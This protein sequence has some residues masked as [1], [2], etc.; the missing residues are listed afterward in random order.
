MTKEKK[1]IPLS[2]DVLFRKFLTSKE[3]LPLLE[4]LASYILKKDVKGKLE[5]ENSEHSIKSC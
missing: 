4:Y 3:I 5:V 2:F 1:F